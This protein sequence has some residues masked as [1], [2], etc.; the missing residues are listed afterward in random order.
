MSC[1]ECTLKGPKVKGTGSK[2]PDIVFVGEAPGRDEIKEGV[3]FVGMA[4]KV[5]R[6]TLS[7]VGLNMEQIY[8]T[9]VCLCRPPQNRD[10]SAKE[11]KACRPRFEQEIK[12]L[13]PKLVVALG[14]IPT[15]SLFP[16]KTLNHRGVFLESSLGY[17]GLITYHPAATLYPKGDTLLP[18][19]LSDLKKIQRKLTGELPSKK[20]CGPDTHTVTIDSP[21][22]MEALLE[23]LGELPD[24]MLVALDWETTGLF[25]PRDVGYCLG[26]SWKEGTGVSISTHLVRRYNKQLCKELNRFELTGYNCGMFDSQFNSVLGLPG[27]THDGMLLHYLLDERP[28]KRSLENISC[29]ELDA[30][31]YESEM[32][33]QYKSEKSEMIEKV[34][35]EVI[36]DYCAMDTDWSLRLTKFLL[37]QVD[38]EP[39]LKWVYE[40]LLIPGAH[41]LG[42]IHHTG[43]WV[44]REKLTE[45]T[46]EHEQR[47]T[48]LEL[49]LQHITGNN[50]FN[51]R[52]HPQV[53]KQLWDELNLEEPEIFGREPRSANDL[54][55][56]ALIEKYPEQQFVIAL[57]DYRS[58][59]T[60][61]SRY[62]RGIGNYVDTDG[63]VRCSFHLDRT[64]TGRLSTTDPALHQIP[65]EGTIR[66]IFGAPPG[67]SLIQADYEQIEMRTAAL[68]A[69]DKKLIGLLKSGDDFHSMMASQAFLVPIEEVTKD[70]RQA[71]KVVSFGLLYLM[72][73]GGLVAATGLPRNKATEF[74]RRYKALMPAVQKTIAETK[75]QVNSQRYV[76]SI[77]G[78]RRRFPLITDK[79][80]SGLHR[81]AVNFRLGQSPASDITLLSTIRLHGFLAAY[82][83][84]ARIV[85]TV[86]DSILVEC[87]NP[88]VGEV[89]E[90]MRSI[91]EEVPIAGDVPFPVEVKVGQNWGEGEVVAC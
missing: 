89:V 1:E 2:N 69:N 85:L 72:S 5:L 58:V 21:E 55:L 9:N 51:P 78:R 82:Y 14:K 73:D 70:Q 52:S 77:F 25:P 20:L 56:E 86:H 4:G 47:C 67:Y 39:G 91:M 54:T 49:Y 53:H 79:N 13:K 29:Q 23:R 80:I 90:V 40:N 43:I 62:L 74:V 18:F 7:F 48:Q 31:P 38:K 12:E 64:E 16:K 44:S 83:P 76:E 42:N 17:E 30:P 63:R 33:A 15:Q 84:E 68:V 6:S 65:R 24:K 37:P 60:S 59:Y 22:M 10:P 57:R 28:Q 27:F 71:A 8:L 34:P 19:I 26:M 75:K 81:E 61:Y 88:L 3:P 45:V 66:S 36:H 41:V 35:E 50:K 11:M 46:T 32:L 87:P